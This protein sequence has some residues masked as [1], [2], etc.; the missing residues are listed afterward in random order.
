[1]FRAKQ[2][3]SLLRLI[4]THHREIFLSSGTWN[5]CERSELLCRES[6]FT[7]IFSCDSRVKAMR[8]P[9]GMQLPCSQCMCARCSCL[10]CIYEKLYK[11][12]PVNGGC[13]H[14]FRTSNDKPITDCE[15]FTPFSPKPFYKIRFK[16]RKF[17]KYERI[18]RLLAALAKEFQK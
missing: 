5:K 3:L 17:Q 4:S 11:S 7:K 1:M 14:C 10:F 18:A 12:L 8:K 9:V 13:Y 6:H 16:R 15:N 2:G